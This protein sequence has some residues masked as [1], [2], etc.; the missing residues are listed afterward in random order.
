MRFGVNSGILSDSYVIAKE[1]GFDYVEVPFNVVV[2]ATDEEAEAM[3][4]RVEEI[5]MPVIRANGLFPGNGTIKFFGDEK[6]S[7]EFL[8]EYLEK[9]LSRL[10]PLGLEI[11]VWG[12]GTARKIPEG[13][14]VAEAMERIFE[15]GN[16]I[17]DYAEKYDVM[18]AIE[19]LNRRETNVFNSVYATSDFTRRLNRRSVKV[20]ADSYHMMAESECYETMKNNK[21]MIIHTHI[22]EAEL[23]NY[24]VRFTPCLEDKYNT[25][26]FIDELKKMG[27]DD[28]VSIEA[29]PRTKQWKED[30]TEALKALRE[31]EK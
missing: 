15:I 9:G 4:A 22:A 8:C 12:S 25:R 19:P 24:D 17:A 5:G 31:W 11:L 13:M 1:I 16:I 7:N 20:L 2:S 14:D 3:K 6:I 29:M 30:M 18:I 27:Y 21:D 28:C 10:K 23:G 26:A